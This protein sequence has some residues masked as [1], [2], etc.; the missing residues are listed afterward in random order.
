MAL[1]AAIVLPAG[2]LAAAPPVRGVGGAATTYR[3]AIDDAGAAPDIA[4]ITIVRE[5]GSTLVVTVTLATPTDLGRN[6]WIVIGI[7]TDRNQYSGGM[8][9]SEVVVL[10]NSERAVVHRLGGP[11]TPLDSRLTR[12]EL[13][14]RLALSDVGT[15]RFDFAVATL[16]R[17][18][19]VAP[20]R[21]VF[22]YPLG[23]SEHVGAPVGSG[24]IPRGK[25]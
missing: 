12:N 24:R 3:D 2:S 11:F 19:D 21:G 7:D 8:H 22:S 18:A 6:G 4:A 23:P 20:D 15:Q 14:F 16:R 5:Q 17:D 25:R 13:A 9:G 1:V 10:A